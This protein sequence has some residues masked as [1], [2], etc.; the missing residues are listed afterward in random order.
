MKDKLR[1]LVV[2]DDPA[3][4]AMLARALGRHGFEVESLHSAAQALE[5]FAAQACDAAVLDL[6]MPESDG[7]ELAQALRAQA[8]GLP[9]AI[10]TGYVNSPLLA[11]AQRPGLAVFKK[12]I[13]VP[14][15]IAFLTSELGRQSE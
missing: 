3:I 4:A 2:D 9:I 15:V 13:A 5:R 1:I 6:V 14:D 8:P 11:E 7:M 10:L 12:P